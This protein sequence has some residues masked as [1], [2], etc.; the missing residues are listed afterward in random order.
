MTLS[1]NRRSSRFL[2]ALS[3]CADVLIVTH[4]NPDPDAIASSW[5]LAVLVREK[6][7][8][9]VRCIAGG[10]IVRA[11]NARLVQLLKPPMELV[12]RFESGP[13]TGIVLVDCAPTSANQLL[14][15]TGVKPLA[16]IDHHESG[17]PS[18]RV[19]FR[20]IRKNVAAT[21]T[22][23]AG[24]LQDQE[25][26]PSIDLATALVYAVETDAL[27]WPVYTRA[28][29][30]IISWATERA[31][32]N[33]LVDIRA[34]PLPRAYF[35]DL[36]LAVESTHVFGNVALAFLPHAHGAEIVGEVADLLIRCDDFDRV[37]CA[38]AINGDTI[39]SVRTTTAGG[40]ASAL[41]R[42]TLAGL[43]NGGGHTH[44]AGGKVSS[45]TQGVPPAITES[46]Q[47]SRDVASSTAIDVESINEEAKPK[48]TPLSRPMQAELRKRWLHACGVSNE[49]GERLVAQSQIIENL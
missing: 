24:Y 28:D 41:V 18:F 26:E 11:E 46:M 20:D 19:K 27:G 1:R 17:G 37:L 15:G 38:A 44:R 30:R 29:H 34:A 7:A 47:P 8:K 36:L 14:E 45:A 21:A 2:K 42:R 4:D 48:S 6:L 39:L 13:D 31:D 35:A 12:D 22:I 16:V 9:P 23:A 49:S 3:D 40:D 5:A 32:P 33:K 43:G 10:A 25:I